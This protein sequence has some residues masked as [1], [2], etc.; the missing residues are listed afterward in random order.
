MGLNPVVNGTVPIQAFM[1]KEGRSKVFRFMGNGYKGTQ[2][3]LQGGGEN[4]RW[5]EN[6]RFRCKVWIGAKIV[7]L[8]ENFGLR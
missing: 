7:D 4:L 5:I 3:R 1:F 2:Y 6:F 8:G